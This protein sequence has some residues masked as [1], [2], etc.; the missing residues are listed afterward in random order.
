MSSQTSATSD[1]SADQ[2]SRGGIFGNLA[3]TV[4]LI[5]SSVSNI[6]IGMFDTSMSWL[7][8]SLNPDP[9]MV[10]AVQ[11]AT[12]LPLF[13]LTFPAGA[14]AD[15]STPRR[16]LIGAPG[17]RD[18]DF[19][20]LRGHGFVASGDPAGLLSTTFLLGVGG[21][22]AAPAWLLITPMLVPRGSRQRDRHQ[23][24]QLTT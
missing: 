9:M 24:H 1:S 20:R 13:L 5:A 19:R 8:T 14:L 10:S 22:I 21:A 16:L 4:I 3:F 11:V 12:W 6:G 23:Q 17:R 15:S 2:A 7:M 18:G